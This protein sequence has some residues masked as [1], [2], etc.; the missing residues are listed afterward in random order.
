MGLFN[1]L[2]ADAG[3]ERGMGLLGRMKPPSGIS[4]EE[5]R[6]IR[7]KMAT[8]NKELVDA[9]AFGGPSSNWEHGGIATP[10]DDLKTVTDRDPTSVN[11]PHPTDRQKSFVYH[12][13]PH[14]LNA[15]SGEQFPAALSLGDIGSTLRNDRGITSLD[16]LGGFAYAIRNEKT[17]NIKL[18]LWHQMQI[19]ARSAAT[20]NLSEASSPNWIRSGVEESGRPRSQFDP[21]TDATSAELAATLGVGRALNRANVLTEFGSLPVGEAQIAGAAMLEPAVEASAQAAQEIVS[22]WLKMNGFSS[23]EIR[24]ALATLG[25]GG[26][27]TM[28]S[29]I[30][31]EDAPDA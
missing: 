24:S 19:D 3:V 22:N 28:A 1:R 17:P 27:L 7:E 13:H 5:W 30:T 20:K 25:T 18:P 9:M 23:G 2:I 10:M 11:T 4:D 21:P 16:P 8:G 29:Q 12:S 26:I 14:T 6:I 15:E 31:G